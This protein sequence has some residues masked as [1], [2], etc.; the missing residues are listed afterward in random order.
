MNIF[1]LMLVGLIAGWL[2][3]QIMK[4]GGLGLVGNLLVGVAGALLGGYLFQ[5]AGVE[6]GGVIG[7]LVTATMGA[8][9]ILFIVGFMKRS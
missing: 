3:G 5:S 2:A 9:L 8:I 4:N 7:A 1:A 6:A